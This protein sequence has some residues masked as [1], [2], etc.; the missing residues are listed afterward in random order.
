MIEFKQGNIFDANVEAIVNPVNCVGIM[1]KG[2]AQQFKQ[3]YPGNFRV[4]RLACENQELTIGKMLTTETQNP[5]TPKY[6]INFPTKNH[7]KQNS[8]IEDIELGLKAL[9]TEIQRLEITSIAIPALGCGNGGLQW[10]IVKPLMVSAFH[11]LPNI[12]VIIFEP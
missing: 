10:S 6:I 9:V 3:R 8:R 12:K 2:L 1:G 11:Q 7:W 4:Y 5:G